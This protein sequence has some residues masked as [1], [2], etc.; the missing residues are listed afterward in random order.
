MKAFGFILFFFSPQCKWKE[1]K[2]TLTNGIELQNC[3][4]KYPH[5]SSRLT[6]EALYQFLP[7]QLLDWK[8]HGLGLISRPVTRSSSLLTKQTVPPNQ[9][10][11]E[12]LH[13]WWS[14][15]SSIDYEASGTNEQ[16][17]CWE[18]IISHKIWWSFLLSLYISCITFKCYCSDWNTILDRVNDYIHH[19]LKWNL[20]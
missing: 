15:F 18:I 6:S 9:I 11:N 1:K 8:K 14:F 5:S 13:D 19:F 2:V 7:P 10:L 4:W 16:P 3:I 20:L 12:V 17:V